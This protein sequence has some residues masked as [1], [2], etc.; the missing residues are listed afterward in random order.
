MTDAIAATFVDFKNVK[1]RRVLQIIFEVPQHQAKAALDMLGMPDAATERWFGIAALKPETEVMQDDR[2]L[3]ELSTSRPDQVSQPRPDRA[4]RDWRDLPASQQAALRCE[5]A[6]FR[7][8]LTEESGYGRIEN[9]IYAAATVRNIC[10][11]DSRADLDT[12]HKARVIWHQLDS[13]YQAWL[14]KERVG[15]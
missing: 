14:A 1:T 7:A 15:A 11:V 6:M 10:H 8:F 5:D 9:A 3:V 12:N 2:R 4:K 13:Q